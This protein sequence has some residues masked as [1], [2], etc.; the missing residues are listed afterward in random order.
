MKNKFWNKKTAKKNFSVTLS[1]VIRGIQHCVN[2][3]VEVLENHFITQLDKYVDDQ[4][5]VLTKTINIDDKHAVDIPL[6]CMSS[7]N[8]LSLDEMEVKIKVNLLDLNIKESENRYK[9]GDEP[10][11]VT[12][13]SFNIDVVNCNANNEN[14][15][16]ISMKFKSAE[17]PEA[18][19]RISEK[20]ANTVSIY[21]ITKAINEGDNV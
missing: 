4:N 18:V 21:N 20:L 5:K 12:R 11:S 14:N 8:A 13:T 10:F 15:I 16:D 17:T 3:S 6:F 7:H 9:G 1:D 19:S 2:S